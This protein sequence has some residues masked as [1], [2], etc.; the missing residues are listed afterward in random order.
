[1]V[2]GANKSV[3]KNGIFQPPIGI[4]SFYDI[5][6]LITM[7][8]I[9]NISL[10]NTNNSPNYT[11]TLNQKGCPNIVLD[12]SQKGK[13]IYSTNKTIIENSPLVVY[14]PIGTLAKLE[15]NPGYK[16]SGN[17]LTMCETQGWTIP[18]LGDC[19]KIAKSNNK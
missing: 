16:A 13:I 8:N 10:T 17:V 12:D 2:D 11:E 9:P 14:N 6:S 19:K 4:C 7:L 15:C 3:C 5:K 18:V 1:M